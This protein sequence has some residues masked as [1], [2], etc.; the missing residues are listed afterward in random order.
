MTRPERRYAARV[1]RS[2]WA[3]ILGTFTL[4]LSTGLTGTM[5][6][7]YL[8]ELPKHG[9]EAVDPLVL[10][11]FAATFYVAELVL[12]PIFGPLADRFGYHRIMQLGPAFGAT[13]VVLTGLT[14]N[15]HVLGV[16]RWLEGSS[17]AASVPAILGYIA[18]ATASD[19]GIRGKASARFELATLAGLGGGFILAGVLWQLIGPLGFFVNAGIYGISWL[20]YRLGVRD[21]RADR[22]GRDHRQR[23]T[24]RRYWAILS[25][26]H[27]WL[28]APTWI[29]VN[30]AIGIWSAQGLFAFVSEP[31]PEFGDQW[32]VQGFSSIAVSAAL[33][34]GGAVF[35]A[36]L[37]YWGNR[38][39]TLRRTTIIF[40]GILGGG[41]LVGAALAVNHGQALPI[42][43]LVVFGA[44][45]VAGLFVLAGATPAAIGLLADMSEPY[46]EDRGA[47]MGLYSVFLALGQIIGSLI[48]GAAAHWKAVDGLLL[49]TL[50]LLVVALAPLWWLRRY[51]HQVGGA[52]AA[53]PA[54]VE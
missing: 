40:Y 14:T 35:V 34:A 33:L 29:A 17:T 54:P 8:A 12:S 3:V 19:E 10:G 13:A 36:G 2:L 5:L 30:A 42:P 51:E 31:R 45:F 16:T 38:F 47:I 22:G 46:P 27:V 48:G 50:T 6:V 24:L 43:L 1:D 39:R 28:L 52:G 9:G 49:A 53:Q 20:I 44:I 21:P 32:L 4:R 41:A 7:Y 25:G 23:V 11:V 26:A 15:L 37:I 18:I